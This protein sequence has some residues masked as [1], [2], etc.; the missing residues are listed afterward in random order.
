M[1]VVRCL[2][3]GWRDGPGPMARVGL[4]AWPWAVGIGVGCCPAALGPLPRFR[5]HGRIMQASRHNRQAGT[6]G[7]EKKGVI[8]RSG[9]DMLFACFFPRQRWG[10]WVHAHVRDIIVVYYYVVADCACDIE[11]MVAC[12]RVFMH[13]C[14]CAWM[15][16]SW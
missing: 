12:V 10:L 7:K 2:G 16:T 9:M 15:R 1:A 3:L 6:I 14:A 8:T 4:E 11:C 5:G 13:A